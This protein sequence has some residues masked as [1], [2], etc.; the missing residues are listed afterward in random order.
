MMIR[1]LVAALNEVVVK[2]NIRKTK[3]L[4]NTEEI[5]NLKVNGSTVEQVNEYICLGQVS[6]LNKETSMTKKGDA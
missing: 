6:K 3:V 4:T 5:R 1:Q 2:V